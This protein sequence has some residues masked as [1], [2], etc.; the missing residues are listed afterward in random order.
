MPQPRDVLFISHATPEDNEF[1]KW[2]TLRLAA[3][4]YPVYCEILNL[5]GGRRPLEKCPA[6]HSGKNR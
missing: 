5:L 6:N 1:A 3:E 4:G 2:L